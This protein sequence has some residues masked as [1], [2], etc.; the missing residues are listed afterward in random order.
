MQINSEKLAVVWYSTSFFEVKESEIVG[1]GI[2]LYGADKTIGLFSSSSKNLV[3]AAFAKDFFM[4]RSG[5]LAGAAVTVTTTA[6]DY[7][8]INPLEESLEKDNSG[9]IFKIASVSGLSGKKIMAQ[10][11]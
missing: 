3:G 9:K 8:W 11:H 1:N 4:G 6:A 2:K 10:K 5:F 7:Y